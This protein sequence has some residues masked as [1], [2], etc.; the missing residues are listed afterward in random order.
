MIKNV[1]LF[2]MLMLIVVCSGCNSSV[3]Q[4]VPSTAGRYI[5]DEPMSFT[6]DINY[7][8]YLPDD[9]GKD[10]EKKWPLVMFL[11]G[12]GECGSDL[13][14]V[15]KHGI[16]KLAVAGQKFDFILIAPQCPAGKFWPN[17]CDPLLAVIDNAKSKWNV[18]N[19]RVYLTGL[20]MGGFGTWQLGCYSP[21][22]FAAIAPICGA[23]YRWT[24]KNLKDMP[25]WAFHGEKD[26]VVPV[27]ESYNMIEE[28]KKAGGNPKLTTYPDLQHDSWTVTY[29]NPELYKWLLAQKKQR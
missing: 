15:E 3:K 27:Q 5:V 12:V 1:C 29:N 21:E 22:T 4:D 10:P 17:L 13:T 2:F 8:V 16:P 23:G 26:N 28:I 14:K 7:L 24:A 19:D 6:T 25:V 18:D 9:Y 11:H 20:S